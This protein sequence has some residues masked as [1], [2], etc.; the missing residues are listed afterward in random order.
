MANLTLTRKRSSASTNSL[1]SFEVLV[2]KV[3][4]TILVGQQRIEQEKVQTYWKTGR[5]INQHIILNKNKRAD[6]GERT[7]EKLAARIGVDQSVLQRCKRFADKYPV[8]ATWPKLSWS[9]FRVLTPIEDDKTRLELTERANRN[10]WSTDKLESVIRS[11]LRYETKLLTDTHKPET[12]A[13]GMQ[14]LKPKLGT[15]YTYRLIKS[16]PVQANPGRL[17]VDQGFRVHYVDFAIRGELKAGQIVES[18]KQENGN[19]SVVSS[20]RKES[21]LYTYKAW[22][23]RVIDGDTQF[24]EIDLGFSVALEQYLRLRGIDCPEIGTSE[25]K[26]A[27]AFVEKCLKSAPFILLT[28][29]RSDKYDRYLSDIFVPLRGVQASSGRPRLTGDGGVPLNSK[30]TVRPSAPEALVQYDGLEYLYL[31]N[32]LLLRGLA[33]RM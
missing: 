15:L 19:Y 24:V 10:A 33:K 29:S 13:P 11:E 18:R 6:L 9:H 8:L 14:L 25:G 32:E 21:D 26:K 30:S 28:S 17:K 23:E 12:S 7:V 1:A 2:R 22:V 5:F 3:R 31:N 27:K 20:K 4:E 16:K